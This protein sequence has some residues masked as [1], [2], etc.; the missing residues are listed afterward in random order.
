MDK[1]TPVK[2][3]RLKIR[4]YS[5]KSLYYNLHPPFLNDCGF[6]GIEH[7]SFNSNSGGWEEICWQKRRYCPMNDPLMISL[8]QS[9]ID[10]ILDIAFHLVPYIDQEDVVLA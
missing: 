7:L 8:S 9:M 10:P 5:P 6:G 1:I 2:R 3:Y 4:R